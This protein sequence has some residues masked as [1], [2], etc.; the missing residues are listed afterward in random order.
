MKLAV[1]R[2]F[3][4]RPLALPAAAGALAAA[5]AW[6]FFSAGSSPERSNAPT[7]SPARVDVSVSPLDQYRKVLNRPWF[8][9]LPEK[10]TEV[11]KLYYFGGGGIGVFEDG[12]NYR[13][14]IDVF[15]LERQKDQLNIVF[16]QDKKT[17]Q[18]KFTITS[19]DEQ[20]YFDL[21]L[22]LTDPPRGPKR[23]YSWDDNDDEAAVLAKAPWL[24]DMIE[25]AKR[26]APSDR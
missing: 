8:E 6:A 20:D 16:L 21:C 25:S 9:K 18:T 26:N 24:R 13:Y 11:I 7:N 17:A 22:D 15:E 5:A 4:R 1:L 23:Y 12:S 2:F 3:A 14:S 10:R 19:C